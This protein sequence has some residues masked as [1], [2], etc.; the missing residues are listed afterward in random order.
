VATRSICVVTLVLAACAGRQTMM[1]SYD[2]NEG[3]TL[4][5][6]SDTPPAPADVP[7]AESRAE[8]VIPQR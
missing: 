7:A 4:P 8:G 3:S 1:S 6:A 5:P 2:D